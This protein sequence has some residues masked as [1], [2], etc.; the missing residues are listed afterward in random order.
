LGT[1]FLAVFITLQTALLAGNEHN[2]KMWKLLFAQPVHKVDILRAKIAVNFLVIGLS[3]LL[4][5]PLSLA[6]GL[7][8]RYLNPA[9]GMEQSIPLV[10]IVLLDLTVYGLAFVAIA[11][12]TWVS[13]RWRAL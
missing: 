5:L 7:L 6:S 13:L 8:L 3:Q 9:L 10:K 11:L 1:H 12:H 2:G 4:L